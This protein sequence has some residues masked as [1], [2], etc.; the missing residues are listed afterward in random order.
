MCKVLIFFCCLLIESATATV[1]D[2]AWVRTFGA[3]APD[4]LMGMVT[5]TA[6]ATYVTGFVWG[7]ASLDDI[8][9]I[10]YLPNG[11]TAWV[12][13]YNGPANGYDRGN[14]IA[15]DKSGNVYVC[16][17]SD[18]TSNIAD[19]V[20][21][22]YL[23]TGH[24][25]WR[26]RIGG[27]N[28]REEAL[29]ITVDDS[30]Y[31]YVTG[32]KLSVAAGYDIL[33]VKYSPSGSIVWQD[34]FDGDAH[35][36]EYPHDIARGDEGEIIV[37]GQVGTASTGPQFLTIKYAGSGSRQ[38]VRTFDSPE[39]VDIGLCVGVDAANNVYVSG[40]NQPSSG[41]Q[42][43]ITTIKY[44]ADGDTLWT[45]VYDDPSG[46]EDFVRDMVVDGFGHAYVV[47]NTNGGFLGQQ[48][49][50]IKYDPDG[51]TAWVRAFPGAQT[52]GSDARAVTLDKAGRVYVTG[53]TNR[54]TPGDQDLL[55]VNLAADGTFR[56]MKDFSGPGAGADIGTAI[57]IDNFG[58][59]IVAGTLDGGNSSYEDYLV[60]K[61]TQY[62]CGDADDNDVVNISDAVRLINYIFSGG[63]APLP[64]QSGDADCSGTVTIS[65]AVYLINY[66]FGG[67][68]VPCAD[69]Q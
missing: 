37:G 40:Y 21:L 31:V 53:I 32:L 60:I 35:G 6:G 56:W 23:P 17:M 20:V 1:V 43:A 49:T 42:V 45:S 27:L 63:P 64:L 47:G 66:I 67:G 38:W 24:L 13:I 50:V 7:T 12:R 14:G 4:I 61:Y 10:K 2:T 26:S 52:Q 15:V 30:G 5:D 39:P 11:D 33:T 44:S 9:T 57:A 3:G 68:A 46:A 34:Q 8:A 18:T 22:K 29:H 51:D 65:D 25:E 16:G 55:V 58:N 62:D 41:I 28:L 36:S 48:F 59:V 69:C 19:W 54:P